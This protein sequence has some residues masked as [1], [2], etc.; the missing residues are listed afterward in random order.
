MAEA[1]RDAFEVDIDDLDLVHSAQRVENEC[2]GVATGL[3]DPYTSQFSR[4]GSLMLIDFD[5]TTHEYVD[6]ELDALVEAAAD[7]P[8]CAG[9]RMMGGGFGGCTINLVRESATDGF[10]ARV[11]PEFERRFGYAPG[12]DVHRLVGGARVH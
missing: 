3:M 7:V 8:G 12:A 4:P 2:L 9:A 1:G 6:V 5:A 10:V 11:T